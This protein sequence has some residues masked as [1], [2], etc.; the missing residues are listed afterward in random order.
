M[1]KPKIM[2]FNDDRHTL[3]YMYEPPMHKEEWD[4]AVDELA[5][6]PVEALMFCLGDGRTVMHDSKVAEFTGANQ[7]KWTSLPVR[8]AYQNPKHLIE[9]GNDPL[10]ITVERAHEKGMLLYP[11]LI[12]QNGIGGHLERCSTFRLENR[13]LEIGAADDV[14]PEYPGF[15]CLDFK[16]EEVRDERFA[17]IEETVNKYDVD[18]FELHLRSSPYFFH[19]KEID[20]GRDVMTAW[21]RRVYDA[22]KRSGGERELAVHVPVSIQGCLSA[23]LDPE[24]WV[25]Q[26]IVDVI[27]AGSMPGQLADFRPLVGTAKGSSTRIIASMNAGIDSD[28]LGEISVEM[29]RAEASNHW[30]QGV[31][32][33]YMNGWW[34]GWPYEAPFYE[35]LRE[36]PHPDIMAPKDK[37]YF[38]ATETHRF[39]HPN[40]GP[41]TAMQLPADLKLDEPARVRFTISDDLPG[42]DAVGRVHEVLLRVRIMNAS[43]IDRM[44]FKLNGEELPDSLLRKINEIYR[45]ASPRYRAGS[46]YWYIYKLDRDHWPVS[47]ENTLE[48]TLSERDPVVDLQAY[49]RDVEL[50]TKYLR[51]KNYHRGYVDPDLGSYERKNE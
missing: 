11:M 42:W 12:V 23:G 36:L 10:R 20:Q 44:S 37:Y 51:G 32:G 13:H 39:P 7:D 50:E 28:R 21:V 14:G 4:S 16:H 46:A 17:L 35:K 25:H 26:G 5:G 47:G 18:G 27:I 9:E 38:V 34:G 3:A 40:T 43:E 15:E 6:T 31:D 41:G 2:F 48:V 33:I 19:P 1:P 30:D 29:M 49:V 24:E 8:R 45:M 22:V